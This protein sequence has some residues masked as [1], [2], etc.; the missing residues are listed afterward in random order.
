M[1]T[2]A[3]RSATRARLIARAEQDPNISGAALVGSAA[4]GAEDE[5][6]DIDVVLQLSAD[7]DE[8]DVVA[9]WSA[10][11]DEAFGVADTLDVFAGGVRYR[12]FL[13]ASSLQIDVSFW[14]YEQFRATESPFQLLFGDP[15]PPSTPTAPEIGHVVGMGWLYA[16]HARSATAR[17]RPWQAVMMLDELRGQLIT[18]R[19]ARHGL[20]PWHGREVDSLPADDLAELLDSRA[21]AIDRASLDRSR[22][23]LLAQFLEEVRRVDPGRAQRLRPPFAELSAA[24]G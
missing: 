7:A 6:S 16:L 19:C 4:R 20:N 12:V 10:R 17:D 5:W 23:S 13:L 2:P 3:D 22:A 15:A 21:S 18:L 9:D 24:T 1:F 14:P 11:I 8:Q